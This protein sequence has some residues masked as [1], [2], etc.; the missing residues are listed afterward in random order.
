MKAE[1]EYKELKDCTFYPKKIS[2]IKSGDTELSTKEYCERLFSDYNRK[3]TKI[4]E[5]KQEEEQKIKINM[6]PQI[7]KKARDLSF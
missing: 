7:T 5:K 3:T 4:E 6:V 1:I 2:K